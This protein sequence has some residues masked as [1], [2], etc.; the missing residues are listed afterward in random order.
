[1][2]DTKKMLCSGSIGSRLWNAVLQA[3]ATAANVTWFLTNG[4]T[5]GL[6]N[7]ALSTQEPIGL[8]LKDQNDRVWDHPP[9]VHRVP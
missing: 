6:M 2:R 8:L 9:S 1:M 7:T 3:A 4:I 5:G